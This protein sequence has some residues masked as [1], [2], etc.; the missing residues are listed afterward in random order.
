MV[1]PHENI[2]ENGHGGHHPTLETLFYDTSKLT[3][4]RVRLPIQR[5][6]PSDVV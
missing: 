4:I 2:R 5:G 3:P 1:S 6:T